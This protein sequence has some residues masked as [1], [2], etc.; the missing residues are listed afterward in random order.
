MFRPVDP[1]KNAIQGNAPEGSDTSRSLDI[2]R[3]CGGVSISP[4]G[5]LKVI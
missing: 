4:R 5:S 3:R 2:G 1:A